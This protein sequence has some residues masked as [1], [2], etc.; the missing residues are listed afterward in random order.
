MNTRADSTKNTIARSNL[1]SG[2]S[3][4][5]IK[6]SYLFLTKHFYERFTV[7]TFKEVI[8]EGA[9][10]AQAL[11]ED[12]TPTAGRV[13]PGGRGPAEQARRPHRSVQPP[14]RRHLS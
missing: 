13:S 2:S 6:A 11:A 4:A 3:H 9:A 7:F 14:K 8:S 1:E 10:C 12:Q 5:E